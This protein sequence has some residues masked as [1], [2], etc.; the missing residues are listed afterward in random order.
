MM[1]LGGGK[2]ILIENIARVVRSDQ[3]RSGPHVDETSA[4]RMVQAVMIA[5]PQRD[6]GNGHG[7]TG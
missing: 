7:Q 3:S 1:T 6:I 5:A 2:F 4:H